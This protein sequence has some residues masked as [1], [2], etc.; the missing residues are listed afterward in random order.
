MVNAWNESVRL[1]AILLRRLRDFDERGVKAYFT[2]GCFKHG[3]DTNWHYDERVRRCL[4]TWYFRALVAV[5]SLVLPFVKAFGSKYLVSIIDELDLSVVD[6]RHDLLR[7]LS[8]AIY[9]ALLSGGGGNA[10]VLGSDANMARLLARGLADVE[11]QIVR[12]EDL[13][14]RCRNGVVRYYDESLDCSDL[15]SYDAY[16][17]QVARSLEE[18]SRKFNTSIDVDDKRH[19]WLWL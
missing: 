8:R 9:N 2:R 19:W 16:L 7:D 15:W 5:A 6:T 4:R 1:A 11:S 18:L 13:M 3:F 10:G 17:H 14:R 12:V